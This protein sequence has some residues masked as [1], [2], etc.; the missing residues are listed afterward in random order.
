MD[1]VSLISYPYRET[2]AFGAPYEFVPDGIPI[3]RKSIIQNL[4]D[5]FHLWIH[6][7]YYRQ[8]VK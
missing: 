2:S 3:C 1:M 7:P 6:D 4:D 5:I 8:V